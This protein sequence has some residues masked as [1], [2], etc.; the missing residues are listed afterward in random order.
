MSRTLAE[1][2][3][4]IESINSE[5]LRV[6]S[7]RGAAVQEIFELKLKMGVG[8]Y[9]SSREEEMLERLVE[10][11]SGPYSDEIIRRVFG[12]IFSASLTLPSSE[13]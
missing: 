9:D 7:R 1:M 10:Q 11:N 4:E 8:Y 12:V 13:R 2:R 5:L 6:L 3:K